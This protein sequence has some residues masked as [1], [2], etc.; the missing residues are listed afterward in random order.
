MYIE[1]RPRVLPEIM[2]NTMSVHISKVTADFLEQQ[3]QGLQKNIGFLLGWGTLAGPWTNR[4]S[5][6]THPRKQTKIKIDTQ[7]KTYTESI[8]IIESDLS[9]MVFNTCQPYSNILVM[10]SIT[11]YQNRDTQTGSQS[12]PTPKKQEILKIDT[13]I[14]TSVESKCVIKTEKKTCCN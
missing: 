9:L 13:Q 1:F 6:L 11:N 12:E 3:I 10:K 14:S 2:Q 4:R 7:T 8:P 5:K